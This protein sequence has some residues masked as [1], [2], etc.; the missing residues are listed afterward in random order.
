[1]QKLQLELSQVQE[2]IERQKQ[3]HERRLQEQEDL[4]Q[5]KLQEE[6]EK[7]AK[8]ELLVLMYSENQSGVKEANEICKLMAKRIKFKQCIIQIMVDH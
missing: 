7:Q 1:M 4:I 3:E 6:R 8:Q 2:R 5:Q